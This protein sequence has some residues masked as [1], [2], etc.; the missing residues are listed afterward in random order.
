M[1][2]R[3][4]RP[5]AA[6]RTSHA[7]IRVATPADAPSVWALLH[8]FA[9]YEALSHLVTGD[10]VRL[11][12]HLSGEAWPK[13]EGFIAEDGRDAVGYALYLGMFSS[14][15][16]APMVWLEDL[17]VRESHR[18]T[19]LGLALIRSVA[20]VAVER[21]S[22]RLTWAVLDSNEPAIEF[23][24]RLGATRQAEWHVYELEGDPLRSL[25]AGAAEGTKPDR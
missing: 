19:G 12:A 21:G 17:Y 13:V 16:A 11:A 6:P 9:E 8:E 14:F 7:T 22:P 5:D 10:A 25:A 4:L 2:P 1:D 18:G 24:R 15:W 23:Y 20:R 3:P